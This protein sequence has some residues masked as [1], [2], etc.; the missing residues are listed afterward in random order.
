MK[1]IFVPRL[2]Y[3]F[4]LNVKYIFVPR[5]NIYF[6]KCDIYLCPQ[7][8]YILLNS[9]HLKFIEIMMTTMAFVMCVVRSCRKLSVEA[10]VIV[11]MNVWKCYKVNF[12]TGEGMKVKVK[13]KHFSFETSVQSIQIWQ[14]QN[15]C[16][17]DHWYLQR[18]G[19]YA[20]FGN[21]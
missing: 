11:V 13:S 10:K 8:K 14:K 6:S 18:S 2:N 20:I 12:L 15:T 17:R 21:L 19:C 7:V 1:Y 3:I 4:V 16:I 5:L 9:R